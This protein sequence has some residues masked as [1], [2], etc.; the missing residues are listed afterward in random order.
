MIVPANTYIATALAVSA[1]GARPVLVDVEERTFGIDPG[2]IEAA[3]TPRTKAIIPVHL[4]GQPCDIDA[5]HA[6]RRAARSSRS[7]RTP[8]R[9]TARA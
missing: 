8:V 3:I 2:A 9:R 6:D 7:S 4:Y 1:C 5:V